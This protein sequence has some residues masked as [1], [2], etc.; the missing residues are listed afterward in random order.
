MPP[1][2]DQRDLSALLPAATRHYDEFVR[3]LAEAVA[4]DSGTYDAAGVDA[5]GAWSAARLSALGFTVQRVESRPSE[6]RPLG[7]SVVARRTGSD[8]SG[9]AVLLMAH[10][11]TVFE[12]GEPLR[13]PFSINGDLAHGPGVTD[14]KGGLLTGLYAVRVLD[15]L[16]WTG[17]RELVFHCSPDEEIGSPAS[18]QVI[19]SLTPG[20]D[21]ALCLE[22]ARANGDIVSARKGIA[23]I[24]I[25]VEGRAAHAGI[26]PEKGINAALEAAHLTVALQ[27]LNG[28]W[29]SVTC[30][31][32]VFGGGTRP[33][34]VCASAF[35]DVDL[36]ATTVTEFEE[37]FAA[38]EGICA[39]PTVPGARVTLRRTAE[40]VPWEKTPAV[41][42]LVEVAA[43][44]GE[45]VGV[46]VR[47]A[48]T[49]GAADANTTAAV[50]VPTL[51]GLGPVGG[52]DHS[53]SEWMDLSS[54]PGRIA[55]L[56]GIIASVP[57]RA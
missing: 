17:Y 8:P 30:N 44:V 41:A 15:E 4:I 16:G 37:A 23:D 6:G 54:V 36:R 51:D 29:P 21:A 12:P 25:D 31:V 55:L 13:R 10:L 3:D 52:D 28:R 49:G 11:D 45:A 24:R 53:P 19:E 38:V 39:S 26:E 35:L 7:P 22:C 57:K 47:D 27:E 42:A 33:N 5:M 46:H 43:R 40:H 48:A 1:D 2:T 20:I 50:G 56:A 14:D 9:P 18:R 34:V 32:G